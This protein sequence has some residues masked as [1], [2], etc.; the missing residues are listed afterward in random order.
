MSTE[1]G[2]QADGALVVVVSERDWVRAGAEKEEGAT[3]GRESGDETGQAGRAG[4]Q[5]A[6]RM[7]EGAGVGRAA[8]SG[9]CAWWWGERELALP[10]GQQFWGVSRRISE[11]DAGRCQWVWDWGGGPDGAGW[12]SEWRAW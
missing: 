7:R 10:C 12:G 2:G 1:G 4:G 5:A 6:T 9:D 8:C 11:K 3:R